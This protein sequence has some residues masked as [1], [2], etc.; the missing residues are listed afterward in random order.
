LPT[1]SHPAA[2]T[3]AIPITAFAFVATWISPAMATLP[4]AR[5]TVPLGTVSVTPAAT[6]KLVNC[7]V[8]AGVLELQSTE[9]M[10]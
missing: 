9:L 1:V 5:I 3:A 4:V 7:R 2:E 8:P 10:T 6:A